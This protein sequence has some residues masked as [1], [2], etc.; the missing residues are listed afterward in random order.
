MLF[1]HSET[2]PVLLADMLTFCVRLL[3]LSLPLPLPP[4]PPPLAA[5][6]AFNAT[7]VTRC[8]TS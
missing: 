3:L 6:C 1:R 4:P 2:C 7:A 5:A 8:V